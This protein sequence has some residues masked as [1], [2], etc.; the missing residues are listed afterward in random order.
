MTVYFGSLVK[1]SFATITPPQTTHIGN[2][3][4]VVKVFKGTFLGTKLVL[5]RY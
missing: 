1:Y 2:S 5:F 4:M 3:E